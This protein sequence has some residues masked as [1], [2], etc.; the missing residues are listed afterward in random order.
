MESLS[1][2]ATIVKIA[3]EVAVTATSA[4]WTRKNSLQI[5]AAT[6][7]GR[8]LLTRPL[9]PAIDSEH[10]DIPVTVSMVTAGV[11]NELVPR[12]SYGYGYWRPYAEIRVEGSRVGGWLKQQTSNEVLRQAGDNEQ[13]EASAGL[14]Q[15]PGAGVEQ[16]LR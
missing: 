8:T 2:V 13:A 10:G 12:P 4:T 1:S 15:Q 14:Q 16:A 7:R 3:K 9:P 6:A 5:V 11:N